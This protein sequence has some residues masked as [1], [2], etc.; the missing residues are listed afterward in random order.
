MPGSNQRQLHGWDEIADY[1]GIRKRTAQ[2]YEAEQ[3]LPVH[4]LPGVRGRVFASPAELE[5]WK[6]G[7][8]GGVFAPKDGKITSEPALTSSALASPPKAAVERGIISKRPLW[9]LMCC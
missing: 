7:L 1:L 4:R 6:T 2:K 5:A 8:P 3:S 9:L